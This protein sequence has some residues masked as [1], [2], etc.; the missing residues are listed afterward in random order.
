[1]NPIVLIQHN[2]DAFT[3]FEFDEQTIMDELTPVK[4]LKLMMTL[5]QTQTFTAVK[6]IE[7][8]PL[9]GPLLR[10]WADE[11]DVGW[12]ETTKQPSVSWKFRKRLE[13]T[14]RANGLPMA[15]IHGKVHMDFFPHVASGFFC[16][17]KIV[18]DVHQHR[19]VCL[20]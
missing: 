20:L 11:Q 4:L 1:M 12:F 17:P 7:L 5:H 13:E 2:V 10:A 16:N 18:T 19:S 14:T 15:I 6:S 3:S 9:S 8:L